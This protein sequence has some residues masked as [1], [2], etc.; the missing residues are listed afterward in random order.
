[1]IRLSTAREIEISPRIALRPSFY[2]A[3]VYTYAARLY[4]TQHFSPGSS[5]RREPALTAFL[6]RRYENSS[7]SRQLFFFQLDL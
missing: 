4:Y 5:F 7:T 3:K 2:N 1:M 6:R